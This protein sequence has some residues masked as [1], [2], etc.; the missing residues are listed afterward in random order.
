MHPSP[1]EKLFE[2]AFESLPL[3]VAV[4]DRRLNIVIHNRAARDLIGR[5]L[6]LTGALAA[7]SAESSF[8]D[9]ERELRCVVEKGTSRVLDVTRKD[10]EYLQIGLHP[11][12]IAAGQTNGSGEF[13]GGLICAEDV[14][15]RINIERRLAVSE[16]LAAVG[17]MSA[18]IAHELS[19]PLDGI[20]RYVNL[21]I[22]RVGE[23]AIAPGMAEDKDLTRYLENTR[24]GIVRMSE[25]VTSM[26]DS[27]RAA[28]ATME[29]ASINKIVEDA[30][31]A[32]QGRAIDSRVSL[33]CNF[34]QS[35]MPVVRGSTLFQ[36]CCNIIKN[37]ID[38]MPDG[39]TLTITTRIV[40][41]DCVLT[42]EDTGSG[43]PENIDKIFEPFFTTKSPG[44]GTGLGL[45]VCR[46]LVAK[47]SGT[48]T[49]Q[50]REPRG[51]AFIVRIPLRNLE[52]TIPTNTVSSPRKKLR[53]GS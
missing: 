11:L 26:L 49:A 30:I 43:L 17:K 36:V 7:V 47:Y 44:K 1:F 29:Q 13:A 40:G 39:G 18:K 52:S 2:L 25:I 10:E 23:L 14:S 15:K 3:A 5:D 46:D 38:A 51:S 4:F 33:I 22:R 8:L 20:L 31:T 50:R 37:A 34:H 21:A 24:S 27:S 6:S 42:F 9:W 35:D 32:L 41:P 48:L 45:A 16:R 12:H 19:N 28:P 53:R